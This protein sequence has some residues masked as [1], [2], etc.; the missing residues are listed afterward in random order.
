MKRF[1][2]FV[3]L[4]PALAYVVFIIR[5]I[6]AG[7]IVGGLSGIIVGLPFAYLFGLPIVLLMWAEDAFLSD[8]ISL[9][10]KVVTSACTGYGAAVAMLLLTASAQ[11]HLPEISTFGIV[12]AISAAVCSWLAGRD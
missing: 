9:R 5:N 6:A 8:K 4:G 10:A 2:V 7:K 1:L 3:L 11:L 12:G